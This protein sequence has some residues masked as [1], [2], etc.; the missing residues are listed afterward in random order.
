MNSPK[1][2][3]PPG[4]T[5]PSLVDKYDTTFERL[6][7]ETL[8]NLHAVLTL[9]MQNPIKLRNFCAGQAKELRT[10]MASHLESVK[11][12]HLKAEEHSKE[13]LSTTGKRPLSGEF[14]GVYVILTHERPIYVGITR[15]IRRRLQAHVRN[16]KHNT[17]SLFFNLVKA[18]VNHQGPR[19]S[20]D[21]TTQSAKDIQEW[22]R[23]QSVAILPLASPVERY[24]LE[25]Y[26][27]MKLQ[28]GRWNT[29][30]TH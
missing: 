8:P 9:Q 1:F 28:T 3:P 25:L 2:C 27:S 21:L 23:E 30:E 24:S 15:T 13:L 19:E 16:S 14:S 6:V 22:L 7:S 29:F 10:A 26:S 18:H 20:L 5:A 11:A 17:A 12:F 4:W